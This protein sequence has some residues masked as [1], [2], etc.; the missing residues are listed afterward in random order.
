MTK[1]NEYVYISNGKKIFEE[2]NIDKQE[3][4]MSELLAL[5]RFYVI[6]SD[7]NSTAVIQ[8]V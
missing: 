7:I 5:D 6:S 2:K 4:R 3:K 8:L 1:I